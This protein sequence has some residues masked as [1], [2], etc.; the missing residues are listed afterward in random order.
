MDKITINRIDMENLIGYINT[1]FDFA[2]TESMEYEN[3]EIVIDGYADFVEPIIEILKGIYNNKTRFL[4]PL[5]II[6]VAKTY[7]VAYEKEKGKEIY[8]YA[9]HKFKNLK[10]TQKK[11]K[12]HNFNLQEYANRS[13]GIYQGEILNVELHFDKEL[14]DKVLN[15]H[16]HQTQ[17]IK[18]QKDGALLVSFRASG[19]REII[20]HVFKW[21]AGCKI[22]KPQK[23]KDAYKKYLT[24]VIKNYE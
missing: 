22:K 14:K 18:K 23:L 24:E 13:F 6:Y 17:K 20:Y 12:K 3:A 21:G 8:T 19:E 9:L 4:E 2:D 7:L 15:Y 16:F 1:L 11:F 5:G 10:T